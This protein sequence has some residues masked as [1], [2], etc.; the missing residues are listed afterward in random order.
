MLG[1]CDGQP[2]LVEQADILAATFHPELTQ[3]ETIHRFDPN[4]GG[5]PEYIDSYRLNPPAG[6][7]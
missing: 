4:R 6:C 3:D 7:M 1:R 2:V 5:N